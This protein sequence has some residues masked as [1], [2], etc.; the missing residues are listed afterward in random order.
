MRTTVG[1]LCLI[2]WSALSFAQ[3]P[4]EE[5]A[6]KLRKFN[7]DCS[8]AIDINDSIIGP[9]VSP[10]GHGYLMEIRNHEFGDPY[11]FER[12]H[13][14]V[15]YRFKI[16]YN[17][18]L[19]FDIVPL[20]KDDDF[21]FLIF[22]S[23]GPAFCD[24][25][26]K[27]EQ[28]PV[29]TN[30]SRV[31]QF[32]GG[33]TGL[34]DDAVE[35]YV[36]SGPGDP[37]SQSLEVKK[38]EIYYLVVDNPKRENKGHTIFLHYRPKKK[39]VNRRDQEDSI[40]V[41]KTPPGK[42]RIKVVDSETKQPLGVNINVL[43]VYSSDGLSGND[44]T[45][46]VI[47]TKRYRTYTVTCNKP[48]YMMSVNRFV[49]GSSPDE[50]QVQ[51]SMTKIKVG[52]KVA[53]TDIKFKG[54]AAAIL[55]TSKPA[56]DNLTSFMKTNNSITV[57]VGGHVNAPG[58][59]NKKGHKVLSKARAEAVYTYLV[60]SGISASRIKYKGYGNTQM[61]YPMPNNDKEE[62]A[63]RRVEVKVLSK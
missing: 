52:S 3:P 37:Y 33:K 59:K 38:G 42:M 56:L 27:E 53:L 13:N 9:V 4:T 2:F 11:Y 39:R 36:P 19:S 6:V 21:D 28:H 10:A 8:G 63:N 49:A 43:G 22:K 34:K 5:K 60:S 62:E 18:T 23:S 35:K 12:E 25:F 17:T 50:E 51:V 14:T 30:I 32:E 57:E 41:V 16:P 7:C 46:V 44:T 29:R 1:I 47:E 31:S 45:Q 61:A 54:D 20:V 26:K 48:G 24:K 58:S 55:A 40:A 15:W